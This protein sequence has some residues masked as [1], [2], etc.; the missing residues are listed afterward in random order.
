MEPV[1]HG[2]HPKT[3]MPS[4]R[5]T[6]AMLTLCGFAAI[7]NAQPL[8]RIIR[9]IDNTA[10]TALA[11]QLHPKATAA[12]DRGRVAPDLQLTWVTLTFS[13]SASQKADL[14]QLLAAQQDPKSPSYHQWLTP[15]QYADRFGLSQADFDK[16]TSW[17]TGQGLTIATVARGRTWVAVNGSAAQVENAFQTELHQYQVDGEVHFANATEPSLPA[18]FA[19]V[20]LSI[21]GL[22]DFRMRALNVAPRYT[23]KSGDHYLAPADF[24][25]I[26]D[27][28]PAYSA[29]IDGTGQTI[30]VAGQT[31]LE[32]NLADIARFR[33][34]FGLSATLPQ[35]VLVPGSRS[36]MSSNDLPEADL[37][38]EWSGAVARNA[39]IIYVYAAPNSGGVMSA[40]QYAIDQSL[41]PVIS[42]SYGSCEPEN[43]LS[44]A[45][46]FQAWAQQGN[47]EGITW[48]NAS[49][50]DGAADCN[51]HENPGL[52]VDLPASVPQIVGVGG[53]EFT[54]GSGQYWN[55]SN[56]TTTGASALSYIPETS[57]NDSVQDQMPSASGGGSS[58]YFSQPSWQLLYPGV[59]TDNVRHVP[60]V[61]LSGSADHDGYLVFTGGSEQI[62]GGTSVSAQVFGGI[63][64][65]VNQYQ[66]SS[67]KQTTPGIGNANAELYP[68]AKANPAIIHDITTGNNVVTSQGCSGRV[69]RTCSAV[70]YNAGVGY[71]PVTGLGS[72]DV[73]NLIQ[74]WSG[75]TVAPPAPAV[76]L[77]L[78]SNL[79]SL[80]TT[81]VT[82]LV[83]T[84]TNAT[85]VTPVGSVVFTAGTIALGSATLV[86]SNGVATATISVNGGQLGLGSLGSQ[87]VTAAYNGSSS[88]VTASVI[89]SARATTASNGTPAISGVTNAGSYRQVYAPGMILAVFG[90]QLAPSPASASG[91]PFPLTMAGTS[92]TLN[93][94]A[95]P[96]WYVSPAQ[97]NIQ[98]PYEAAPGVATLVINNNGLVTT[99]TFMVAATAPGIFTD[100]NGNIS[101]GLTGATR[102][103]YSVLYLTGAGA[104][105][106]AVS[107]G[108]A[109]PVGTALNALPAPLQ[110]VTVTVNNIA[111]TVDFAAIPAGLVGVVQVNFLVPAGIPTGTIP[112]VVTVGNA[113]ASANL[114]VT[115]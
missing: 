67:G 55:A 75:G 60:D 26:Y 51:D 100:Q 31:Q 1:L 13:P 9:P 81:D 110:N 6:G 90:S 33:N 2:K 11:G 103:Q 35:V 94:E 10:R 95:V 111:T 68:L 61:A 5:L 53:T 22:H 56:N 71:D 57:W 58:I 38:V 106:P 89:L 87:T 19:G 52:A 24:A 109:P 77:S 30:V 102:G 44:D 28:A 32:A 113:S 34:T 101:D 112:V 64:A 37:D 79:T 93:G 85:G 27:I 8:N 41:A 62:Y 23:S 39:S 69:T 21:R 91:V 104:V 54:E 84:A 12:N 4:A 36:A 14:E 73:W 88:A 78:L 16:I 82:F 45:T 72:V 114:V 17:L 49:G 76:T 3:L 107:S 65:L 74:A 15:E 46:T 63:T 97:M 18:A 83:A 92:A 99:D 98:I 42:V 7:G 115:N 105:S 48:I 70:G 40:V 108:A 80:D 59:A 47:A 96:L 86:G 25:T 20:V 29:G 43:P 66:V 50:D